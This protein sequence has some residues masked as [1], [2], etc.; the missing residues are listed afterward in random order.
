M[1][2][3]TIISSGGGFSNIF[4]I[5]SYQAAAVQSWFTNYPPPYGSDRF[6]NSRATRAYPD[7]SANGANF[8]AAVDGTFA[9]VYGTS[10]STPVVASI[11]ALV[12]EAR[13]DVGKG[14]VGFVNP[15]LYAHPAVLNDVV[16]GGNLGCGTAGFQ[17]VPGWDPVT[18]LGT[19]SFPRLL[20]LYLSLP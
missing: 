11:F 18:G 16:L 19:P 1:A 5:P 2:C 14:S 6:N 12:N 15:A 7:I 9:L 8:V 20:A 17:A 13:M 3:E 4:P 10:A